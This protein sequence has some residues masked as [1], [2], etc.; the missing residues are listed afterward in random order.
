[1]DIFIHL[2]NAAISLVSAF[3]GYLL[4]RRSKIDEIQ[5]A[6]RHELAEQ[7]S[8]LLQ[9]DF[10]DRLNLRKEYHENFDQMK[11][12]SEAM[13]YFD[14]HPNLYSGIRERLGHIPVRRT[15]LKETNQKATIYLPENITSAISKYLELTDFTY[16]TD[17]IGLVDTYIENFLENLLN[18]ETWESLKKL[19]EL[20]LKL[21]RKSL[22]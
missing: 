19:Y 12:L 2:L 10:D 11:D 7:L 3:F 21:L 1:M 16:M 22:N 20:I 8:M 9:G 5:L 4:G 17:G 14:K 18:E 15:S 6:K 13:Y